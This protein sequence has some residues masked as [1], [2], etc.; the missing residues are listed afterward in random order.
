M[1]KNA[2]PKVKRT[3]PVLLMSP[4]SVAS[5][6]PPGAITCDIP[7]IDEASQIRPEDAFGGIARARQVVVGDQKQLPPASFL[8]RLVDEDCDEDDEDMPD[9]ANNAGGKRR[10]NVL[11]SRSGAVRGF[12]RVRFG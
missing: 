1:K 7:A 10:L 11:F 4:I 3:K 2:G 12:R 5:F 9:G 8:D 6:P